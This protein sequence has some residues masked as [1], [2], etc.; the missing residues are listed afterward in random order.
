MKSFLGLFLAS[1]CLSI[2]FLE[3]AEVLAVAWDTPLKKDVQTRVFFPARAP[4][5]ITVLKPVEDATYAVRSEWVPHLSQTKVAVKDR[6]LIFLLQYGVCEKPDTLTLVK[7]KTGAQRDEEVLT[8]IE[9]YPVSV[10][11]DEEDSET[12]TCFV[13]LE[14]AQ[15]DSIRYR[16]LPW[17]EDLKGRIRL[18]VTPPVLGTPKISLSQPIVNEAEGKLEPVI[19]PDCTPGILGVAP[20]LARDETKKQWDE[21]GHRIVLQVQ[22]EKIRLPERK[23]E[24][25]KPLEAFLDTCWTNPPK[26]TQKGLA[27]LKTLLRKYP[28]IPGLKAAIAYWRTHERN[29]TVFGFSELMIDDPEEEILFIAR[30]AV[31][32]GPPPTVEDE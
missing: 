12:D 16:V 13:D 20:M 18:V 28:D 30:F 25:D 8:K 1:A 23:T 7:S 27:Y 2:P 29:S 4:L 9:A 3:G 32:Q 19:R 21:C 17:H 11:L 15:V 26:Y 24:P 5:T 22:S 6:P 31:D 14:E 10:K